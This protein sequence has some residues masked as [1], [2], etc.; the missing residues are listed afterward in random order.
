[1]EGTLTSHFP[2]INFGVAR[3]KRLRLKIRPHQF[4]V[5]GIRFFPR[6][7]RALTKDLHLQFTYTRTHRHGNFTQRIPTKYLCVQYSTYAR[8]TSNMCFFRT[9]NSMQVLQQHRCK[10]INN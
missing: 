2:G 8:K 1:M 6:S 3:L 9:T 7:P 4:N 5:R 10:I